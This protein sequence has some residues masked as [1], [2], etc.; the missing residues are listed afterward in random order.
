M[1]GLGGWAFIAEC[2]WGLGLR[3]VRGQEGLAKCESF[4]T[5]TF[6]SQDLELGDC[7]SDTGP[8]PLGYPPQNQKC[9]VHAFKPFAPATHELHV[10]RVVDVL[11]ERLDISPYRHVDEH[12]LVLERADGG[13]ITFFGLQPPREARRALRQRVD[14]FEV[15]GEVRHDWRVHRPL[16]DADVQLRKFICGH[17]GSLNCDGEE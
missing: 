5:R 10:R 14:A 4:G 13:G 9:L 11:V 8:V 12:V 17:F 7:L 6:G 2:Q 16:D 1:E 3:D 15:R